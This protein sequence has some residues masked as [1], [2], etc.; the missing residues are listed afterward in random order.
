MLDM[1]AAAI[2]WDVSTVSDSGV[3][4]VNSRAGLFSAS[5]ALDTLLTIEVSRRNCTPRVACR[6]TLPSGP[7]AA[8][9]TFPT[10]PMDNLW[11]ASHRD[12][13]RERCEGHSR[14]G[15][16]GTVL[17]DDC[18]LSIKAPAKCATYGWQLTA[19]RDASAASGT[20]QHAIFG[21]VLAVD[22]LLTI[23]APLRV[24]RSAG[25][26]C[27]IALLPNVPEAALNTSLAGTATNVRLP[28]HGKMGRE[29]ERCKRHSR[30]ALFGAIVAKAGACRRRARRCLCEGMP[31]RL[32]CRI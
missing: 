22:S 26:A 4:S 15:L 16:F 28:A 19:R 1:P 32:L 8:L 14:A 31:E 7:Q 23:K 11:L 9:K 3:A 12:M 6:I 30:T 5:S 10:G 24:T 21:G 18:L 25:L 2:A 27:G 13:E 17:A 20:R 29:R